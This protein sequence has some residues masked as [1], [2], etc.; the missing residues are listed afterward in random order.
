MSETLLS[1]R[2][3][4]GPRGPAGLSACSLSAPRPFSIFALADGGVREEEEGGL[5]RPR[6]RVIDWRA[7]CKGS[8]AAVRQKSTARVPI[9]NGDPLGKGAGGLF[10]RP[11]DRL[12]C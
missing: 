1:R 11:V 12:R 5:E 8:A 2:S 3:P 7:P 9:A 10:C 6:L 4:W